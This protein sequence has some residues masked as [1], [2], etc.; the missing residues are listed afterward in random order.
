[1]PRSCRVPENVLLIVFLFGITWGSFLNVC[2]YR[3]PLGKSIVLPA[4]HCPQCSQAIRWFDNIPLL[5]WVLL[6]GRCRHCHAAIS[7]IYP[8]VE[9]LAGMLAIQVIGHFGLNWQNLTLILLGYAFIVLA[10]IDFQHYILPDVITLPGIALGLI[11]AWTGWSAPPL[12]TLQDAFLGLAI[13]GGGLWGFA[14]LFQKITGKVGMGLGDVK[15]LA[16]IGAWM[17]WQSL[18]FTLFFA[19][20]LGT[21]VGILWMIAAR[22][23]R[24]QPIPFG[25]YLVGAAWAYLFVGQLLTHWYLGK[26]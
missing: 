25:P 24:S 2:I 26:G 19:S 10:F 22:R 4:S 13:G 18:P 14:W 11:L 9:L 20:L 16:M 5:G 21:T 8:L 1:M 12:A 23:N 17:G 15:L 7:P 6:R 3:I